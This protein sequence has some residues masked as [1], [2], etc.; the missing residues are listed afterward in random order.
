MRPV[1]MHAGKSIRRPDH[2]DRLTVEFFFPVGSRYI[3]GELDLINGD[4]PR[5][6]IWATNRVELHRE[7]IKE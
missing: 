3:H 5:L 2:T 1:I 6:V 7:E 4:V